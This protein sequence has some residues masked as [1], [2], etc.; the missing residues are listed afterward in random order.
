MDL[1][2]SFEVIEH[3]PE[4]AE[5]LDEARRVLS[6]GGRLVIS[7]PNKAYYADSR[8]ETGPNPFHHHE[9]ELD[10][11]R[12]E[13][14]A[15]FPCVY[16]Y[17]ENHIESIGFAPLADAARWDTSSEHDHP[18]AGDEPHFFLAV[19]SDAANE[20][21]R[22]LLFIPD[23]GNMLRTREL[24]I[25]RLEGFLGR[26]R[27]EKQDLVEMFRKQK[28]ELERSNAWARELDEK[29]QA[30]GRRIVEVQDELAR[31]TAGY[32][33]QIAALQED[34]R[35]KA[36]WAQGVQRELDNCAALLDTAEK[37]VIERTERMQHAE[38]LLAFVRQSRWLKLGRSVGLGPEIGG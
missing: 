23:S 20:P 19:C 18:R 8:R 14:A 30:A 22:P 34:L 9:F 3:V 15:R 37:T 13:L 28:E 35:T 4:W 12:A 31:A 29:L 11:F 32:E 7:T 6:R 2:V 38:Q 16:L 1:V 36:E 25:E 5:F 21:V 17:A 27:A 26:L 10:E 33:A 24:H